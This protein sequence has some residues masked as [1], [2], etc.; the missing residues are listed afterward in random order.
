VA[1]GHAERRTL[2]FLACLNR[3]PNP[4]RLPGYDTGWL[5]GAVAAPIRMPLPLIRL[6]GVA[7][8][9]WA[10]VLLSL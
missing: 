5:P 2:G 1:R 3:L 7:R 9:H 8:E 10:G 4:G 6:S